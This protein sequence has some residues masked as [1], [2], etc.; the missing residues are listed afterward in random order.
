M[1][2]A[3]LTHSGRG[4]RGHRHRRARRLLHPSRSSRI[5]ARAATQEGRQQAAQGAHAR[6]GESCLHFDS[7]HLHLRV[8]VACHLF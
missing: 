4:R 7:S 3:S 6:A 5:A 2:S 8:F 1:T